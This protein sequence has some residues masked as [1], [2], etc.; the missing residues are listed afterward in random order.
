MRDYLLRLPWPPQATSPNGSQ[1]KWRAKSSAAK[2]YKA[3]CAWL[4]KAA[5]IKPMTGPI[6][7][8]V[9]FHPP[10]NG[11]FDLDNMLARCKQGL[12][13]V[14][15]AIGV[16][17]GEWVEMRLT[18]GGKVAGGCVLVHVHAPRDGVV[19]VPV[20]GTVS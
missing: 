19:M 16:D 20:V 6:R 18:R 13:A 5:Q 1:G 14:A 8:D 9:A 12:D 4:C 11:R 2:D 17:D 3:T 10:R 7:V 15:E